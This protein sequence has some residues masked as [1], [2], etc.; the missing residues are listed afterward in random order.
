MGVCASEVFCAGI[1]LTTSKR[2]VAC[3]LGVATCRSD[4]GVSVAT[5]EVLGRWHVDRQAST[6]A[7]IRFV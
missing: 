3:L 1:V 5:K 4:R 6:H 2:L 7:T